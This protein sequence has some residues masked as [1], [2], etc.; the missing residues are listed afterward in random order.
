MNLS[1]LEATQGVAWRRFDDF[2]T[3]TTLMMHSN[4]GV[5]LADT[6]QYHSCTIKQP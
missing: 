4:D 2:M 1:S 6:V 5:E 3:I